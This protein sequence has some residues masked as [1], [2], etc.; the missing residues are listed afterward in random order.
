MKKL[1]FLALFAFVVGG[2]FAVSGAAKAESNTFTVTSCEQVGGDIRISRNNGP[3]YVLTSSCRDAGHGKRQYKMS[4]V[5]STK[6]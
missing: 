4:C 1:Y 2:V 3:K 5:S 6:Y